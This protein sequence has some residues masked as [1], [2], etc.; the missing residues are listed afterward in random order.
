MRPGAI[1]AGNHR[2]D[3]QPWMVSAAADL[4]LRYMGLGGCSWPFTGDKDGCRNLAI[5]IRTMTSCLYEFK[6]KRCDQFRIVTF[7]VANC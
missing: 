5:V 1:T 4:S 6:L 2:L 3:R 7:F